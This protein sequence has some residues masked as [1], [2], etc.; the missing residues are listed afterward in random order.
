MTGS[1]TLVRTTT[2]AL[3]QAGII[4]ENKQDEKPDEMKRLKPSHQSICSIFTPIHAI[5]L[6]YI[7]PT[8]T[9]FIQL[10]LHYD[11][12]TFTQRLHGEAPSSTSIT[13]ERRG[14]TYI[15]PKISCPCV[16]DTKLII[17]GTTYLLKK[18]MVAAVSNHGI[19]TCYY[20]TCNTL[21]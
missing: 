20:S 10:H 18:R 17:S 12:N 5:R 1:S 16:G 3:K 2:L 8:T 7:H 9:S 13:M 4:N 14:R 21:L 6:R 15:L 11:S 19:G